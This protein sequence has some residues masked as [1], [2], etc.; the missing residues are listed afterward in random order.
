MKFGNLMQ[1]NSESV[2]DFLLRICSL[3]VDCEFSC[4][5][6]NR[7]ISS[8]NIKDQFINGLHI[9]TLQTDILAKATQLIPLT[10]L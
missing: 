3:A 6:C 5:A 9:K 10:T 7:D 8:I 2:K 4:E 1:S